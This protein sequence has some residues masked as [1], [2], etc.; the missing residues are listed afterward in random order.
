MHQYHQ[1][2]HGLAQAL[3]VEAVVLQEL[4]S[5][6]MVE[7]AAVPRM[8]LYLELAGEEE[9]LLALQPLE[10]AEEVEQKRPRTLLE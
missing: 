7:V 9:V 8:P 2:L 1:S 5:Q 6:G 3:V 10:L 4:P